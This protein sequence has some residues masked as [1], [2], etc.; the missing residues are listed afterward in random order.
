MK[1]IYIPNVYKRSSAKKK[2]GRNGR[3]SGENLFGIVERGGS[4]KIWHVKSVGA[5]VLQPLIKQNVKLGAMVHSDG[6]RAYERLPQFGYGHRSTNHGI[7][8]YYTEESHTQNIENVWSHLK[9]GLKGVYRR[10]EPGYL[11]LY[12]DEYAWRYNYRK[13]PVLFWYL[14]SDV[15][16]PV[17]SS[18]SRRGPKVFSSS[19]PF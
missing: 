12:A 14:L 5:R 11:Q 16:L 3:H 1:P 18:S 4:V 9:R 8:Q 19:Q 6:Y 10:V 7:G 13:H 17:A 2:Y 15:T